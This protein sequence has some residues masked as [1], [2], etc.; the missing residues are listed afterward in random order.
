MR[1]KVQP[2][3]F[4]VE[5]RLSLSF[6][7]RGPYAVYR[8]VK[9]NRTTLEVQAELAAKLGLP[10]S[11]A[12]FPALKDK[13]A[14]AVQHGTVRLGSRP[15]PERLSG[16]GWQAELV[17][18]LPRPL[19]PKDLAANRFTVTLRD[20]APEEAE[21]VKALFRTIAQEGFPNYFDL[22]RFGSWSPRL[23]FPGKL[24]LLGRWEEA[25]R[26]YL[27][28]PLR[29]DPPQ[30]LRF[31]G[32]AREHWGDWKLLKERAPRGNLRSVLT[33]L[34][35]HPQDFKRA[36]NLITPR[37]LSLWLSAYGSFLW[38]R[39]ASRVI[40]ALAQGVQPLTFFS[41]LGEELALPIYPLNAA[42]RAKVLGVHIPLP[43]AK[44][45]PKLTVSAPNTPSL[46]WTTPGFSSLPKEEASDPSCSSVGGFLPPSPPGGEGRREGALVAQA[47]FAVLTEEGLDA[48]DLKARGLERAYLPRGER[49]LWVL[50]AEPE[51]GEPEP[52]E[53]FPGKLKLTLSFALPPG[54]YATL[55]LRLLS[56][57]KLPHKEARE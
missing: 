29:G 23:G 33:F 34:C 11:A 17:G 14:L 16:R 28:E 30:I 39:T 50:P 51:H 42:F 5:E 10:P 18:F 37:I 15:P 45:L 8:V 27:A 19:S 55:L 53:F 9:R 57:H 25:L 40:Q 4:Q 44:T 46:S 22:Q 47:L 38:N 54:A 12:E 41:V 24:L 3:D 31:K 32:K 52:D 20:L 6:S 1:V 48:K 7:G 43:S 49:A 26:A 2:E 36:V 21:A 56:L 13:V 35:D